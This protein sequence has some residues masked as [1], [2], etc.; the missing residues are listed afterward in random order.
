MALL[1]HETRKLQVQVEMRLSPEPLLVRVDSVQ[2]EQAVLNLVRNALDAVQEMPAAQ[3]QLVISSGTGEGGTV[4][5]R[6]QDSGPGIHP[7]VMQRLFDPF[8]TTKPSGMGVGLAIAQTIV[9]GHQG[10]IRADSWPGKG[11]SFT[12]EL[13]ASADAAQ[14]LAS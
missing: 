1:A 3:R 8:F 4:Y 13:P 14:S 11:T 7:E 10:R 6:V 9:D 12:I 2:I 5:V